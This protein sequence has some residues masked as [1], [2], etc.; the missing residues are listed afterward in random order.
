MIL[1]QGKRDVD[2]NELRRDALRQALERHVQGEVRFD[3]GSRVLYSTDASIY[4]IEPMGVVIPRTTEALST[5]VAIAMEHRVPIVP[6]GAGTSLSGQSIGPGLVIDCSKYLDRVIDLDLERRTVR[7]QPGC[8]LS[9]LNRRLKPHGF[10]FGPDVATIDRANIGGM[11]GNNSA[12][13]RSIR[14]GKTVDNVVALDAILADGSTVRFESLESSQRLRKTTLPT[15][16]GEIYRTVERVLA[17]NADEIVRRFPKVFRR[18][19]GYNLDALLPPADLN[20]AKLIVGSEGTLATVIEAKLSIVPLPAARGIAVLEFESVTHALSVLGPIL[21][22]RPSAVELID[23]MILDLARASQAY[24]DQLSFLLGKPGAVLIVE[25]LTDAFDLVEADFKQL[26]EAIAGASVRHLSFT[27]DP[28]DCERVWS[29]RKMALPLLLSLPGSRKPIT[30]VED[31]AVDPA[32]LAEYVVRFREILAR[33]G[34]DGSFY[35]HASVGCLHIRPL[36]DLGTV[37]G[38]RTMEQIAGE[39]VDLVMEFGGSISGEHGDGLSRSCF[40]PILFGERVYSAFREIKRVFDPLGLMNPG[41]IVDAPPLTESLRSFGATTQ[42]TEKGFRYTTPNGALAVVQECNGNGLCRRQNVGV[43]CPSYAA[44]REERDSPRGRANLLRAALEGELVDQAGSADG[45]QSPEL[46]EAL[47]LCLGCK[48]CQSEC[49]SRVDIARLKSEFL[50]A[51]RRKKDVGPLDRLLLDYQNL[52]RWASRFSPF[53]NMFMRNWLVRR[54]LYPAM[55]LNARRRLPAFR[56]STLNEWFS[57]H[58]SIA[59]ERR[60]EVV[61]LSDCFTNFHDPPVGRAAVMLLEMAGY[62][63]HLANICC[64]RTMI[65]RGFLN[66]AREKATEGARRLAYHAE[67][68]HPILGLEPSCLLTLVDEWQ[69]LDQG[70]QAKELL[71]HVFLAESWLAEQVKND[72]SILPRCELEPVDVLV[73]GHCHQKAAQQMNGTLDALTRLAGVRPKLIDSGCCGMAGSFGYEAGHYEISIDIAEQRLLPA[74]R[75]NSSLTVVAPGFSCRTQIR[76]L[77]GRKA[78]HPMELIRRRVGIT[79]S[80]RTILSPR[81]S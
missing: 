27:M 74:I 30:F 20:L 69:D 15:R 66:E 64:G 24:R 73:H 67:L 81:S 2:W 80:K 47:D 59:S 42:T 58:R 6:R 8:V 17:E 16:E 37:A 49:P 7:V 44:T 35:G 33:H 51:S 43:M 34:T 22:T 39:V 41:K 38:R 1:D 11:I 56:R 32:R 14:Y 57:Q 28:V 10:Q 75:E 29:V 70:G 4:Q 78:I 55:G 13:S 72:E 19:S 71:G 26:K 12:G 53:S 50:Y 54:W 65:S 31:T 76:D 62:Q 9:Q 63:V 21:A 77:S 25:Y 61:L 60:G 36:L 18:V 46:A 79:P 23:E 45:W 40:N 3:A 5:T 68:G 48:A 52:G